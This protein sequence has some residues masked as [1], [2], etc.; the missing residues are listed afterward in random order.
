MAMK[1]KNLMKKNPKLLVDLLVE[2]FYYLGRGF[3]I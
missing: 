2:E 3:I 1:M